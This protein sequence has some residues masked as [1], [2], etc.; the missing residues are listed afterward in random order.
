M[1]TFGLIFTEAFLRFHLIK[2]VACFLRFRGAQ[3]AKENQ[4]HSLYVFMQQNAYE[5]KPLERNSINMSIKGIPWKVVSCQTN[6]KKGF[7]LLF[8]LKCKVSE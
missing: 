7:L 6:N 5:N 3:G 1:V 2:Q 8:C 4:I